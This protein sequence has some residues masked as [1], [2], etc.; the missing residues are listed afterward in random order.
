MTLIPLV[1]RD[2]VAE[3]YHQLIFD[4]EIQHEAPGIKGSNMKMMRMWGH[5]PK[6]LLHF[7]RLGLYLRW[8][9]PLDRRL[10][11]L[12]IMAVCDAAGCEYAKLH[13]ARMSISQFGCTDDD[14]YFALGI[15]ERPGTIDERVV[16]VARSAA[17]HFSAP[18]D[19]VTTLAEELGHQQFLDLLHAIGLYMYDA[20]VMNIT[21]IGDV[22]DLP[23]MKETKEKFGAET[24]A[25]LKAEGG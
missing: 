10:R 16:T 4:G 7:G 17:T 24:I 8:K 11:Q 1:E 25:A 2:Q 18:E 12:A 9:S 23:G 20:V 6:P 21:R 13:H 15:G 14:V 3:E 22:E 19:V 5:S